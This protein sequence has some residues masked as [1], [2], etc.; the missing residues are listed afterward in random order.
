MLTFYFTDQYPTKDIMI[1]YHGKDYFI[2]IFN[3][4][5][6]SGHQCHLYTPEEIDKLLNVYHRRDKI[7]K[8]I[9]RI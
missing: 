3:I 6:T 4:G 7:K 2:D 1:S 5:D 9:S 8:I